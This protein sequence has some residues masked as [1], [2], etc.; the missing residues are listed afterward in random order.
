MAK[1]TGQYAKV[2]LEIDATEVQVMELREWSISVSSEKVDANVA[3]SDWAEHLIG[4]LS[5]E[6][7]ATCVSADQFWLKHIKDKLNVKFYDS[8]KDEQPAYEGKA[9]IDFEHSTPQDDLIESSLT[10]TGDGEL[11][12]PSEPTV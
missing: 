8:E 4:R 9:S 12:S 3:G 5:W 2:M 10:F 1:K 6:G 11:K 7:E